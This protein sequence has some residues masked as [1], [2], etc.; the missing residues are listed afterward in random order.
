MTYYHDIKNSKLFLGTD[1][2]CVITMNFN[3]PKENL[4]PKKHSDKLNKFF[5]RV[6]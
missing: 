2:G 5:W 6:C 1:D 4:L 3:K